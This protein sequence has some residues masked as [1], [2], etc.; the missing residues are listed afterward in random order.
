[1][2]HDPIYVSEVILRAW[3]TCD[4]PTAALGELSTLEGLYVGVIVTHLSA[5][6]IMSESNSLF[7]NSFYV[8]NIFEGILYGQSLPLCF[9]SHAPRCLRISGVERADR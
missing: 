6:G 8:S 7:Q 5:K 3:Q 9:S 1:M 4:P 2:D